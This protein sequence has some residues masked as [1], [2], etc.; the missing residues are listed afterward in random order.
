MMGQWRV[1]VTPGTARKGDVFLHVIHVGDRGLMRMDEAE[2][3]REGETR[4]VRVRTAGQVWEVT[5]GSDG[6]L[7]GRIRGMGDR[8]IDRTLA[9]TVQGQSGI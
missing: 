5:F 3:L 9:T 7:G 8:T 1:E 4:G 2:L 6:A